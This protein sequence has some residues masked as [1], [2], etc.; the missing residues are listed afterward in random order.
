MHQPVPPV[1]Y[2]PPGLDWLE[3]QAINEVE[4]LSNV[5]QL[6]LL[7]TG[8]KFAAIG[9][10]NEE[11]WV[12]YIV[13]DE[14][15]LGLEPG[16][17]IPNEVAICTKVMQEHTPLIMP[18]ISDDPAYRS[19]PNVIKFG[20]Q[21]Y[22]S[23]PIFLIN[24]EFFGTLCATAP[25]PADVLGNEKTLDSM[26]LFSRLSGQLLSLNPAHLA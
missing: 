14:M 6:V 26:K 1:Q 16:S 22:I 4:G 15:H 11:N 7:L 12:A 3:L 23:M 21:A 25:Y 13:N 20:L 8:L 19:H 18:R 5:L 17:T 9:K 24:G 2:T 10:F